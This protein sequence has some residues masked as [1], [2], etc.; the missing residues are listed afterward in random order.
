MGALGSAIFN[1]PARVL[2]FSAGTEL[3]P[4]RPHFLI[5]KFFESATGESGDGEKVDLKARLPG[6]AWQGR[7][8]GD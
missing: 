7:G 1:Q 2:V 5:H 8:G 4:D 3:T 6:T